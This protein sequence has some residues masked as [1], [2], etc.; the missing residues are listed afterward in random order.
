M[1]VFI[2]IMILILFTVDLAA[3]FLPI[4]PDSIF[5]WAAVIIYRLIKADISYS[6]YFWTGAFLITVIVFLADYLA[7]A[8]FIKK[9][10]YYFLALSFK[11]VETQKINFF[12]LKAELNY[13]I[14]YKEQAKSPYF[15]R[16]I[17]L[18]IKIILQE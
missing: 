13:N 15:I 7:N 6:P 10:N 8:Y 14:N 9:Q 5:F 3:V 12:K 2:I 16:G 11:G 18:L 1:D 4:L 17:C